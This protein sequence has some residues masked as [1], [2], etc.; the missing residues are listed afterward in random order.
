MPRR[1]H[2]KKP[3]RRSATTVASKARSMQAAWRQA[4]GRTETLTIDDAKAIIAKPPTCPYCL[5]QVPWNQLSI[6]HI[7]PK[8]R[9]GLSAS[10]NLVWT[11][12]TCN[13]MKGDL[14]GDEYLALL[15][16][17]DGWPKMKE[18]IMLRLRIAG[19][20]FGRR[21]RWKR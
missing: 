4:T 3:P 20:V 11:C 12:R 21:R 17:L 16:F 5:K 19:A 2:Y 7:Q 8:S 1:K 18:S 15:Q 13:Q 6:D 10:T 14:I 9:D